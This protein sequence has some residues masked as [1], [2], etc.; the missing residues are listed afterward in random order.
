M[1]LTLVLALFTSLFALG[2]GSNC[3]WDQRKGA[4]VCKH[5]D[6]SVW[7]S[8]G[9]SSPLPSSHLEHSKSSADH[10]QKRSNHQHSASPHETKAE[11]SHPNGEQV[12][13]A[14]AEEDEDDD[15]SEG[16]TSPARP[17]P[18]FFVSDEVGICHGMHECAGINLTAAILQ[19]LAPWSDIEHGNIISEA[20][21]DL[22]QSWRTLRNP[23]TK[24]MAQGWARVT[25]SGG[26][27]YA[28]HLGMGH[29]NR[30]GVF[31]L[32]LLDLLEREGEGGVPDVDF[33][34][35]TGETFPK[36]LEYPDHSQSTHLF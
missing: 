7:S 12:A 20:D 23:F 29:G 4:T 25:I 22:A 17:R 19:D 32:Q 36:F 31:L 6:G 1:A 13:A 10:Q 18:S 34:L 35:V 30:D 8:G 33:I 15:E 14:A 11:V 26:K 28:S 21:L 9:S 24:L 16:P 3:H 5:S 27:L 2:R